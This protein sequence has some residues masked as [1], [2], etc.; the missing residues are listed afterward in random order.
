VNI[1]IGLD[2]TGSIKLDPRP[3]LASSGRNRKIKTTHKYTPTKE[4]TKTYYKTS[5]LNQLYEHST[6]RKV[7]IKQF[8]HIIQHRLNATL[9]LNITIIHICK[10]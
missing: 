3:T 2:W 7:L 1:Q 8:S 6:V 5:L 4:K 9:K 10:S